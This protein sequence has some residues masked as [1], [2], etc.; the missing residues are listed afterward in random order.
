MRVLV[1]RVSQANVVVEGETVGE[2]G[3]GLLLLVG[4][5]HDDSGDD[6]AYLASKVANL[7]IFEDDDGK[8]NRSA[9]DLGLSALVV[10]QFTLYGNVRKGRRPSF[11]DAAQPDVASPL[12]ES[13]ASSLEDEG[14]T[15][16]RGQFQAHMNVGL[17]NDGPVTIWLDTAE[18]R[19][20]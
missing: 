1:Q 8:M 9:V 18:L 7:R 3:K 19:A 16:A 4:V 10:S 20:S 17:V 5:T 11:I 14:L 12:I 13:L 2:I 6:A 15:V